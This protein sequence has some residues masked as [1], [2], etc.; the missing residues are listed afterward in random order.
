MKLRLGI[1]TLVFLFSGIALLKAQRP[2][3]YNDRN[4]TINDAQQY[5]QVLPTQALIWEV[6]R[7]DLPKPSYIFGILYKVPN[8]WFFLPP[9]LAPIVEAT[10]RLMLEADPKP[11]DRDVLYRWSCTHRLYPRKHCPPAGKCGS[12]NCFFRIAC[13]P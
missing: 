2:T 1:F 3:R 5:V 12:W 13:R 4:V 6:R 7:S 8:D 10:D 9:G 11:A